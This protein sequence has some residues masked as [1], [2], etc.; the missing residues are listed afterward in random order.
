MVRDL[1]EIRVLDV[2]DAHLRDQVVVHR[3]RQAGR[4]AGCGACLALQQAVGYRVDEGRIQPDRD[5]SPGAAKASVD[6]PVSVTWS[7]ANATSCEAL[8]AWTGA[9]ATSGSSTVAASAGGQWTYTIRCAGPGGVVERSATLVVPMPVLPTSYE[10]AK[11]IVIP[12]PALP[13]PQALGI[14]Q[15]A[16]FHGGAIAYADFFQDGRYAAVVQVPAA[17]GRI[18]PMM[19]GCADPVDPESVCALSLAK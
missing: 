4:R 6:A 8:E 1:L 11:K 2:V 7:S 17:D 14:A 5:D 16:L 3:E 15:V 18:R 9:L 19:L 10:N 13:T 12:G